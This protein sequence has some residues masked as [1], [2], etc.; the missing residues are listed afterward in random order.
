MRGCRCDAFIPPLK[1]MNLDR[2]TPSTTMSGR[3]NGTE[4]YGMT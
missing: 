2:Y 4:W 3:N 1:R